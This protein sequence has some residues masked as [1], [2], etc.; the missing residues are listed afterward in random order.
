MSVFA[1]ASASRSVRTLVTGVA[2]IG[3][4]ALLLTGCSNGAATA[5]S[6]SAAPAAGSADFKTVEAGDR[7]LSLKIGT[8]LPQS[9]GLAFLGPPEEAGVQLAV[10]DVKDANLGIDIEAILRDSGDTT[11]DTATVSV[12]DLLSQDVSAI[13]GAASSGVTKTVIDQITGAGVVEF[14]PA[15][16]SL[17]FTNYADK[18]L[19][20]RTAPSDLLQGEVLGNQIADDGVSTLGLIVL[21]DSYGTGLAK[22]LT[23][24]FESSGGKVVATSLFNEG[25]SNFAAQISEVTAQ[26]PD[27]IALIT[28]DQSKIIVPALVGSGYPGGKLYFVDGNLKDYKADFAAGLITGSKGTLPGLDVG[29]LGN[30]T[31][32]LLKIDPTLTDYSYAAE[33]YDAVI[34]IA[35]A[36]YA[37]NDTSG[38]SIADYLRQVSGG[39]GDGTKV[40]DFKSGA[41]ALA[42]GEQIN[43]DGFSG[44]ITFDKNGDPTEATIGIYEYKADNTYTRIN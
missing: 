18:G 28:F 15:N 36:A 2:L 26:N 9:G 32:R 19:Y 34:L 24:T 7:N 43:Y 11:T 20:W 13:I 23:E 17:D 8:I 33:S 39:T 31:E 22:V 25:D 35:L 27:A 29:T 14:S 44:P 4:S 10:Q 12:T 3:V 21:N 42:K 5:P 1:K 30:F 40:T 41:E 37:A 6:E 38:Q 16:T